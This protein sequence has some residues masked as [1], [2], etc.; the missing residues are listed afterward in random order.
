MLTRLADVVE[1]G[2]LMGMGSGRFFGFV[3]GGSVPA[4]LGADWLVTAWDQNTGLFAPS[5]ATSVVEE[6]A[7]RWMLDLLGLP[8]ESSFAFVTGGQMANTTALAAARHHVLAA[9][10]WD[11][12]TDGLAG[13]P[14]IRLIVGEEVHVTVPRAARLL[15][16]GTRR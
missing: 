9:V 1:A 13:S 3:I 16:L 10:G 6:I 7:G 12:E 11:V 5:P 15:G 14:P 4:A 8:A 2:G